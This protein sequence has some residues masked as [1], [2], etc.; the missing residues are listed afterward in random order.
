[1]VPV[2]GG[3]DRLDKDNDNAH[4]YFSQCGIQSEMGF[5]MM[6]QR[7]GVL[8][9][10]LCISPLNIGRLMPTIA[11][12]HNFCL[13]ENNHYSEMNRFKAAETPRQLEIGL[14]TNG[15]QT[16]PTAGVS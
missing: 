15:E 14:K 7:S 4:F 9:H 2:F 6:T 5:G 11:R 13:T 16:A 12:L 3:T 8:Q 1:L 10:P